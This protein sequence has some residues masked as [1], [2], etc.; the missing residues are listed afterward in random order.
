MADEQH[1][2]VAL[3]EGGEAGGVAGE[4]GIEVLAQLAA[5]RGTLVDEIAAMA[6]RQLQFAVQGIAGRFHQGE[7]VDGGAVDG[8]QIG[9]VGLDAG[10]AGLAKLL[11]GEGVHG[12]NV[13]ALL[14]E[15]L[16]RHVMV[17]PGAFDGNHE[18]LDVVVGAGLPQ[19]GQGGVELDA[20]VRDLGRRDQHIAIEVAEHPF[21]AR[22]GAIDAD[23]AAS[24]TAAYAACENESLTWKPPLR[25]GMKVSRFL[26]GGL[27]CIYLLTKLHT[28]DCPVA[29]RRSLTR[30]MNDNE[31]VSSIVRQ[32]RSPFWPIRSPSGDLQ[33]TRGEGTVQAT[34]ATVPPG[35]GARPIGR[36]ESWT[37]RSR[38]ARSRRRP[39]TT[40]PPPAH[41]TAPG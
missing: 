22:L 34:A 11:G 39:R 8:G 20:V 31:H 38:A 24:Q 23:D 40:A 12:A 6:D 4:G 9:V 5:D 2:H 1:G 7:A 15:G 26:D 25:L 3:P 28:S 21:E 41:G 36:A 14:R 10:I 37:T 19:L 16:A 18:V 29:H 30:S 35:P 27:E 33:L 13:A 17:T 32:M